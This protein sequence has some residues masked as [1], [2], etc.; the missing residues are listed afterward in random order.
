[1][2]DDERIAWELK[3]VQEETEALRC[4][5]ERELGRTHRIV[6]KMHQDAR[7]QSLQD[8]DWKLR[9][10]TEEA[11]AIHRSIESGMKQAARAL[12][13]MHQELRSTEANTR[14]GNWFRYVVAAAAVVYLYRS[15]T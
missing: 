3:A 5:V 8:L 2:S 10:L 11:E 6:E 9:R 7:W 12:E 15:F 13:S 14:A 1:V 4:S